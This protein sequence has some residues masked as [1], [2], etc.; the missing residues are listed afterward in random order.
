MEQPK[1]QPAI[2]LQAIHRLPY[3]LQYLKRLKQEGLEAVS[4][5]AVAAYFGYSEIQ[6]R[7]DF[8]AVSTCPG[9][10]KQGFAI[11]T[12]INDIE[13]FLGCRN[14]NEAVLVGAGSLGRA[15]LS[16]TGFESY[17]LKIVAA[18]DNNKALIGTDVSG[19]RVFPAE[20]IS[21]LSRRLSIHIGIIAVPAEQAQLVCDQ[22]VAGGVQA[23]WNLAPVHLAVPSQILV[24]NENMAVSLALLSRHLREKTAA[25]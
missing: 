13:N 1:I 16:Y 12:L 24:Q 4:A 25:E 20:R 11:H 9:K 15:L 17:G 5:S 3:Y 10:P 6:V 2:S 21:E 22:L 23:I 8:S 7:K 19:K 18:F 14:S